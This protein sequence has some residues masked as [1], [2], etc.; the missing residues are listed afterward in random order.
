VAEIICDPANMC[1][2]SVTGTG[3]W[4]EDPII[5]GHYVLTNFR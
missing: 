3:C 5:F 1:L 2:W 4:L